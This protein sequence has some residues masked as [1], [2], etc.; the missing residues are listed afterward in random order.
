MHF[1]YNGK[2]SIFKKVSSCWKEAEGSCTQAKEGG[3]MPCWGTDP[4][5]KCENATLAQE[6]PDIPHVAP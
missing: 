1:F 6:E 3:Q 5:I 4:A 2:S